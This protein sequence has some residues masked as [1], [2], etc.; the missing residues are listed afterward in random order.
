MS[1]QSSKDTQPEIFFLPSS[2]SHGYTIGFTRFKLIDAGRKDPFNDKKD[3]EFEVLT[4]YPAENGYN[5]TRK[6][7]LENHDIRKLILLNFRFGKKKVKEFLGKIRTSSFLDLPVS[8]FREQYPVLIFSHDLGALPEYYTLL[9]EHLAGEGY[10]VF[11]INH[12]HLSERCAGSMNPPSFKWRIGLSWFHAQ[13]K[14]KQI[15]KAKSYGEKWML[16]GR[17]LRGFKYL[18]KVNADM[19]LDRKF[20]ISFLHQL[21]STTFNELALYKRFSGRLDLLNLGTIGHGWGGVSGVQSL[22]RDHRVKAAVNIDGFQFC[23]GMNNVINKPLL[24]I[25]SQQYSGINE[26]IYFCSSNYDFCTIA[27]SSHDNFTD[28]YYLLEQRGQDVLRQTFDLVVPFFDRH[29]KHMDNEHS[30]KSRRTK[31]V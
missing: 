19:H 25:Y 14:V 2:S 4:W 8:N 28:L 23:N 12:P 3:R 22:V 5:A 24:M 9:M 7:Y 15:L 27:N 17:L 11:S 20:L 16:S 13:L 29:L 30:L 6:G 18:P 31:V 10:F 21:N 26:G 1:A